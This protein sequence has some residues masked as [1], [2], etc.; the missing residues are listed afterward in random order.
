M[1]HLSIIIFLSLFICLFISI[2]IYFL[3]L[4]TSIAIS[5]VCYEHSNPFL[6]TN[7]NLMMENIWLKKFSKKK[8]V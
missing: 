2:Y 1:Y 4:Q 5:I 7:Q 6:F 8:N 3:F